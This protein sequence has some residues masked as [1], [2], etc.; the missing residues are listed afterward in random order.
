MMP[1]YSRSDAPRA[2]VRVSASG[3]TSPTWR[4]RSISCFT[5][6]TKSPPD[7]SSSAMTTSKDSPAAHAYA[8]ARKVGSGS[9]VVGSPAFSSA[10]TSLRA[11]WSIWVA[12][13]RTRRDGYHGGGGASLERCS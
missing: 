7:R 10:R 1:R 2:V 8:R 6:R 3:A 13:S 9:R 4:S 11:T 12:R 5:L